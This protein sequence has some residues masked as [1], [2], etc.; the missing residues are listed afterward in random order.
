MK[1]LTKLMVFILVFG[2]VGISG[3]ISGSD[4]DVKNHVSDIEVSGQSV[5]YNDTYESASMNI[6]IKN[7]G[8]NTI[9]YVPIVFNVNQKLDNGS[10]VSENVTEVILNLKPGQIINLNKTIEYL[11][12]ESNREYQILILNTTENVN[13]DI[14]D[15]IGDHFI[16]N[17][18]NESKNAIPENSVIPIKGRLITTELDNYYENEY[19]PYS[20]DSGATIIISERGPSKYVGKWRITEYSYGSYSPATSNSYIVSGYRTGAIYY[21]IYWPE[22]KVVG[23]HIIYGPEP[24]QRIDDYY[25]GNIY[26]DWP[27]ATSWIASLP[28]Q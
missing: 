16:G 18:S 20:A 27:N 22:M 19:I 9:R 17:M 12:N 15:Q 25:G 3:C 24:P 11:E 4:I 13:D 1:F 7:K 10:T 23:K 8:S 28:R 2:I 21:V 5:V 14:L 6:T 26:G